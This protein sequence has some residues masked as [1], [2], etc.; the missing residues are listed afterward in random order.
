MDLPMPLGPTM[1]N[2]DDRS[3]L[4][5]RRRPTTKGGQATVRDGWEG[6]REGAQ[7]GAGVM[8]GVHSVPAQPAPLPP[9]PAPCSPE[10]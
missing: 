7:R 10:V 1:A 5:T 9:A 4:H 6:D 2:R 8:P 3:R